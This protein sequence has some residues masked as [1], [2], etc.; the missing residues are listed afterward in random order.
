MVEQQKKSTADM[1]EDEYY[2]Y[3]KTIPKHVS[4]RVRDAWLTLPPCNYDIPYC[5]ADC[6]YSYECFPDD[7]ERLS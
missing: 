5:H 3:L 7:E 2:E 1:S 6:P 4:W